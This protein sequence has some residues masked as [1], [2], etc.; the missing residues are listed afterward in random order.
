MAGK[1]ILILGGG[2]GGQVAANLLRKKIARDHRV[3]LIDR[4]REY[5]FSPSLLWLMVGQRKLEQIRRPLESLARKGIEVVQADVT[6]IDPTGRTVVADD[7]AFSYDDL[8]ISL[9]ADL[10]P[11]TIPGLRDTAHLFYEPSGAE[12]LWEA[13]RGIE[14]GR[15]VILIAA[16]PF[17]CPAAP[18]E[19]AMLLADYFRKRGLEKKCDISIYTPE[20]LPMPVA[21]PVMG[22]AVKQMVEERGIAFHPMMKISSVEWSTRELLF[23]NGQRTRYDLLVAVP[24]HRAP[25]VTKDSGLAG[26]SGWIPVDPRTLKTRYEG[27]YAIGDITSIMLPV[28][29]PL[30]KAGVFAHHQAETVAK[31]I[32]AEIAGG[33]ASEAFDGHGYC[34][35]EM[36]SG[37]AGFAG[38][39][40][41]ALPAPQIKLRR[42]GYHWHWGKVLFERW[43]L[44]HWF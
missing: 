12:R 4:K 35:L 5:V 38:G 13:V 3:I 20:P 27:V 29:K 31:N 10:A 18:Y 19:A 24:P 6:R 33:N 9:G 7:R 23:E 26:E 2:I 42:P 34:F 8:I 21:G 40:F 37:R 39:N 14:G 1:T 16:T 25:Q 15:V 11:E 43:W 22:N 28:G 30:P 17:K 44:K 36:G 41:Y 32:A